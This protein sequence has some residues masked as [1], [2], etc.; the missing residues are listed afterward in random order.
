MPKVNVLTVDDVKI[1]R[2]SWW[3]NWVD[4]AVVNHADDSHLVQM[5]I[6]RTNKKKFK[7]INLVGKFTVVSSQNVGDLTQMKGTE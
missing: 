4:V 2:F 5:K 3:S 6:S 7:S 1:G